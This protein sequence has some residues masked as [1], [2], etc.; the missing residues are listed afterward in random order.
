VHVEIYQGSNW[1]IFWHGPYAQS[2][3]WEIFAH[4]EDDGYVADG[5]ILAD[6]FLDLVRLGQVTAVVRA[7]LIEFGLDTSDLDEFARS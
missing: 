3:V 6:G 4:R 1:K 2:F 5:D 7:A